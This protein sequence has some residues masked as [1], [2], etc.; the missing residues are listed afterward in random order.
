MSLLHRV[1]GVVANHEHV[2]RR[3]A[4]ELSCANPVVNATLIARTLPLSR[5]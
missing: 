3:C 5:N 2:E 1:F 4:C